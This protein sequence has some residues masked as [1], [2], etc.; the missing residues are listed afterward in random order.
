MQREDHLL[1]RIADD[2]L[3]D[4]DKSQLMDEFNRARAEFGETRYK[5]YERLTLALEMA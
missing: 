5:D 3:S 1:L 4:E 2:V